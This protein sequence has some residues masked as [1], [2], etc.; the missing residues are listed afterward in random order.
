MLLLFGAG[1][2]ALR[3]QTPAPFRDLS[4]R[5]AVFG[6][7]KF[8]RLYLPRGYD[9][10]GRRY[11][12]VYFFHGWGGRHYK[13]DNAKLEYEKLHSLVDAYQ[14]IMVMWDGNFDEKEPR[15][16]NVGD[17]GDVK[18]QM[19]MSDCFRELVSHIDGR[20]RTLRDRGNRGI[21]G[22]SMGG[23]VSFLL[24][25]KFPDM[26]SSAV[27]MAGSPE[28]FVGHPE[29]HTLYPVRY[30]FRN[31]QGVHIRMQS[32]DSDILF[33]LNTE[34]HEG[35]LWEGIPLD[36]WQFHGGHMVDRP[37]ETKAFESALKF[38]VDG[39][40]GDNALPQNWTHYDVYPDFDVWGYRV[41][42]TKQ[43]PGFLVLGDVDATGF[44]IGSR[45]WLPDGPPLPGLRA[46]VKTPPVYLPRETYHTVRLSG[47]RD[48]I[49]ERLVT[50]G[51]DGSLSLDSIDTGT[52]VGVFREG[53]APA[54][55]CLDYSIG[56]GGRFLS[57]RGENTLRVRMFNRAGEGPLPCLVRATV[58]SADSA[59]AVHGGEVSTNVLPGERVVALPPVTVTCTKLPP[60]HAGPA[61]VKF[62]VTVFA[63]NAV[64]TSII[65]VP[66]N[67][68]VPLFSNLRFDDGVA[69]REK[70]LGSGNADGIPEAGERIMVYE[71]EHRLRLYADDP[72]II[73]GDERAADE[74]IPAIWPDGYTLSSVIHISPACPE[75]HTVEC[76]ASY[77]TK[78]YNPIERRVTWGRVRFTVRHR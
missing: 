73:N 61:L 68:D 14:V 34:V 38:T 40:H 72:W 42:S 30:T 47:P 28:F 46:N 76:L 35:A 70:A 23:F 20:Y 71:G 11:P 50:S 41:Q 33:Y 19:Q 54:F 52:H 25:G 32:G 31:L 4:Y 67:F 43:G 37:G 27:S 58:T 18:F 63:G 44:L 45:S 77:E 8:Y 51:E 10:S 66:V 12:V 17:H 36:Y 13:D 5:S 62:T 78:S 24:A 21:I 65:A 74:I 56:S 39:F 57:V 2:E 22:F 59:V 75:G 1:A 7:E 53:D 69:V 48:A 3:A 9:T 29:N 6:R 49:T 26:V 55:V 60:I 15:P 64:H 16:Y